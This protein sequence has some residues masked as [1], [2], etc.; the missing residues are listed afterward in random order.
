MKKNLLFASFILALILIPSGIAFGQDDALREVLE[1]SVRLKREIAQKNHDIDGLS[2]IHE[3]HSL[4]LAKLQ[5]NLQALDS[6]IAERKALVDPMYLESMTQLADSLEA[7]LQTCREEVRELQLELGR[8]KQ[9]LADQQKDVRDMDAYSRLQSDRIFEENLLILTQRYSDMSREQLSAIYEDV[10]M[11]SYRSDFLEYKKRVDAAKA[12]L[13]LYHDA[14]DALSSPYDQEVVV[15]L[16]E[17]IAPLLVIENDDVQH[18]KFKLTEAQFS[19]IDS[20]DICLSRYRNGVLAL[21]SIVDEVNSNAAVAKFIT[22]GNREECLKAMAAI[23]LPDANPA[24]KYVY[25]RYFEPI[26]YLGKMV[27]AYWE[28]LKESP[29]TH[30]GPIEKLIEQM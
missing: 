26:P 9:F 15:R 19:E 5:K 16:R 25:E 13:D 18:G 6:L 20:L 21:K 29:L 28:E 23:V 30:P 2:L 14:T 4:N 24:V 7:V 11:F 22:Q 10:E 27:Q 1:E 3:Q 12:N 17:M 8:R